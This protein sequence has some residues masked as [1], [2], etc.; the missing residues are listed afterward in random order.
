MKRRINRIAALAL[1]LVCLLFALPTCASAAGID[2][3]KPAS[4]KVTFK[5]GST[6]VPNAQLFLCRVADMDEALHFTLAGEFAG[7][8]SE[9]NGLITADEWDSA[10]LALCEYAE[11]NQ[12]EPDF[13]AMTDSNGV[14]SFPQSGESLSAGLYLLV[15]SD[16]WFNGG[17]YTA[18]PCL[19]SIP[20]I[21]EDSGN[22]QYDV[23]VKLKSGSIPA[24]TPTPTPGPNPPLPQTGVLW[25]P[26]PV[27][28]A[29]GVLLVAA[30]LLARGKKS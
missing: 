27:L 12:I 23:S 2:A 4:L 7:C 20:T 6:E 21:S 11:D 26:V 5:Y 22:W 17:T 3:D 29:A 24:P 18:R 10:A 13:T 14:A 16:T 19:V 8:S 25:W 28:F 9:I 1:A 30:G 15:C